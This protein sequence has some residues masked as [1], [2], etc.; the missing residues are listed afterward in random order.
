[1]LEHYLTRYEAYADKI[2]RLSDDDPEPA[3]RKLKELRDRVLS[4][5]VTK[6]QIIWGLETQD[7]ETIEAI[8]VRL[9]QDAKAFF[10]VKEVL[11]ALLEVI[12]AARQRKYANRPKA[13]QPM[14]NR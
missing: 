3:P 2:Q 14:S 13:A 6:C 1:M 12:N 7:I 4:I 10:S 8:L 5:L 9:E 11:A